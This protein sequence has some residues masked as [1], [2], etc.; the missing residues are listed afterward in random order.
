[1]YMMLGKYD[2]PVAATGKPTKPRKT[3]RTKAGPDTKFG[4]GNAFLLAQLGAH[5]TALFAARIT[6]LDLTLP[7]AG[8]LRIVAIEP[9]LS[10]QAIAGRLG[11]P[12]SR[13]VLLVDELEERGIIERRRDREDRRNHA[14]HLTAEGGRLIGHLGRAAAAHE[15]EV[16]AVLDADERAQ[17]GALLASVAADHGLSPGVQPGS[18]R[19]SR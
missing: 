2:G 11:T 16:C 13:L 19:L 18:V 17:L 9:G 1:M 12:P 10:Q 3:A 15:D 6:S 8:L 7:Q 14:V 5:A 4:V